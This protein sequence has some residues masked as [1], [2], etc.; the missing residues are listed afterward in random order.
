MD[1]NIEKQDVISTE[2][3]QKLLDIEDLKIDLHQ[4]IERA[5]MMEKLQADVEDIHSLFQDC[6]KLVEV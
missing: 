6:T 5:N 4:N 1:P 3:E 2:F